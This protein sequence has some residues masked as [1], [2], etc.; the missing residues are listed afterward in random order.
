MAARELVCSEVFCAYWATVLRGGF[1]R[2]EK[3]RRF[4]PN[5][6]LLSHL[7][8]AAGIESERRWATLLYSLVNYVFTALHRELF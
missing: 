8:N 2:V 5:S 7:A 1:L 3:G 4:E 6:K